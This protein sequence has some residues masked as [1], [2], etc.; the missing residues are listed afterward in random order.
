MG[1][2][3][4]DGVGSLVVGSL[5]GDRVGSLVVGV[6]GGIRSFLVGDEVVVEGVG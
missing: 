1:S 3:V 5:V 6:P 4:G 2:L